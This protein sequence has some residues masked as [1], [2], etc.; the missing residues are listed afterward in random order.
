MAD[1]EEF[2]NYLKKTKGLSDKT[3]Y[4]YLTYHRTFMNWKLLQQN[5]N[6]FLQKK[7]NNS[8]CRGYLKA[9]LEFLGKEKEF[10]IPKAKSG[11]A[12]KRLMRPVTKKEIER[13]R[14]TAYNK[15]KK[16]GILLDLLYFGALRRAEIRSIKVNSFDWEKWFENPEQFCEFRVIG[17]RDK[18]R[19]VLVHPRAIRELLSIYYDKGI[20]TPYMEVSDV[21]EKLSAMNDLLFEKTSEWSVWNVVQKYSKMVLNREI[22]PHDIRKNRATEMME[23]GVPIKDIQIYL[24]HSSV[25]TTEIYLQSDASKSLDRIKLYS[26]KE[27]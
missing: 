7:N 10:D 9:Y 20:L 13:I 8:V 25:S 19:K 26:E 12:R 21:I 23:K 2:V 14:E 24:G 15:K 17:K 6:K 5:I 11:S 16:D 22:R 3:I 4:H 18:E 27:L 1:V